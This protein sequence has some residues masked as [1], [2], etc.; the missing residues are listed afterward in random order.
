EGWKSRYLALLARLA[1]EDDL[2]RRLREVRSLPAAR[3]S[4]GEWRVVE[5]LCRLLR[6]ADAQLTL[7]FAERNLIDFT[8]ITRAAIS[9]LGEDEAP[10]DLAL[11]LD[12]QVRH[13]LVDEFQD[14]SSQQYLLLRRLTAGW[15]PGDGRTLFLVG[16]PMQSIYGFREA[17]VGLYLDTWSA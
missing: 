9:A 15:A 6:L 11:H 16:D 10:T 2:R 17:E 7:L 4:D 14:I 3:Y 12:Y 5:A 13:L 1:E 8:G